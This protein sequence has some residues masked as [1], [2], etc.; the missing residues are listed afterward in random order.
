VRYAAG[1]VLV[2]AS[3]A[4]RAELAGQSALER[5]PNLRPAWHA[6][7]GHGA[8]RIVHRFEFLS[9]AD[10]VLNVPT[11]T[12]GFGL[13]AG[14][15]AGFDFS[16][17]SEIVAGRLG[18]N[19]VQFWL[20]APFR[21]V[22]HLRVDALV[23]YNTVARSMDAALTAGLAA[24]PVTLLAEGRGFQDA[25][26]TGKTGAAGAVGAV[27]RLTP[28]LEL[29]GDLG[30]LFSHDTLDAVWS[31]GV[32]MSIPGTP[33]TLAFH[34]TNAGALTLQGASRPKVIGSETVSVRYGFVF[35]LPLGSARQWARIFRRDP[36]E[37]PS[38]AEGQVEYRLVA[39]TPREIRIRAG[40][41]V[42]WV[43]RDPL[44][45]TVTADDGTWDSGDMEEGARFTRRFDRPGRFPYHCRPHPQMTG[46]VIVEP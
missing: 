27:L 35:T 16:S 8:F 15:A 41:T 1:F 2:A 20:V 3:L 13:P 21:P 43:N 39:V 6:G 32:A 5:P 44:V 34:A 7:P 26:G 23:G 18:D 24:G 22:P 29:A 38:A 30:R 31:A 42:E 14:L 45:H 12:L 40:E 28:H 10:I 11:L 46:V 25:L 4:T 19:E 17:N 36:P 33:H 9:G 37:P